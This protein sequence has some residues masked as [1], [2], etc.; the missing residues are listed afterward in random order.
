MSSILTNEESSRF[1]SYIDKRSDNECWEWLMGKTKG[2]GMFRVP[3]HNKI[4]QA[5]RLSFA[6]CCG[7]NWEEL[8]NLL[9]HQCDNPGCV[10]P[11]HLIPGTHQDNSNDMMSRGRC[12]GNKRAGENNGSAKLTEEDVS[13]IKLL[14]GS[15]KSANSIAKQFEVS[16]TL[17]NGIRNGTYWHLPS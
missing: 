4:R 16:H 12:G 15:G 2:Y 7:L 5:H 9:R 6:V 8:P 1:W 3:S 10:N 11:A 14:L 13:K 17:I